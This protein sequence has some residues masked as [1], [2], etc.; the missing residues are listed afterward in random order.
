MKKILFCSL[1]LLP[2][3]CM[4]QT[5]KKKVTL[6]AGTVVSMKTTQAISSLN[7][8]TT[9]VV[10][11]VVG[12]DIY[13]DDGETVLISKGAEAEVQVTTREARVLSG[14]NGQIIFHPVSTTAFNGRSIEFEPRDIVFEGDDDA[15]L[16]SNREVNLPAG[17]TL[18]AFV[19]IDYTFTISIQ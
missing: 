7:Y 18:K 17:T 9:T 11:C 5:E 8:R 12:S 16:A 19:A 13:D 2:L 4:A 3:V 14:S 6:S 1:C 10:P 15:V